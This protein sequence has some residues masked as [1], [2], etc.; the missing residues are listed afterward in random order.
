M[1]AQ[2]ELSLLT[3]GFNDLKIDL[4]YIE[5]FLTYFDLLQ[6]WNRVYNLTA[7]SKPRDVI[8]KHFFDSLVIRP[9]LKGKSILDVGTGAGFP[10]VP[11]AIVEPKRQF[12]LLDSQIKKI[13]FLTVV[14]EALK[15][16]NI[17]IIHS[18][19]EDFSSTVFFDTVVARAFGSLSDVWK[20]TEHL[21]QPDG[22]LL[23]MKGQYPQQELNDF[24]KCD[25]GVHVLQ[26]PYLEEQ[27]HLVCV[28]S[29][30]P[31]KGITRH[32]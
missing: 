1:H 21:L 13:H 2:S 22:Q 30:D 16:S 12:V 10:S 8:I 29:A 27:R 32:G 20:K 6:K 23:M 19:I 9:Y 17:E 15:L 5:T 14:K 24:G 28:Q 4:A 7:L 18:R 31:N 26:V 3:S 25:L 11:L